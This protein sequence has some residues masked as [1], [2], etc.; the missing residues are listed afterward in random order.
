MGNDYTTL[1]VSSDFPQSVYARI[2]PTEAKIATVKP[3][4][5]QNRNGALST[6]IETSSRH[7]L[8]LYI[9]RGYNPDNVVKIDGQRVEHYK[10]GYNHTVVI[11]PAG[12]HTITIN[13]KEHNKVIA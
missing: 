8:P 11:V 12:N 7:L 4:S 3:I 5:N 13:S 2:N 9:R 1:A 10:A 6:V